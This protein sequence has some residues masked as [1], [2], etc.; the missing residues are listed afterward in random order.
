MTPRF[1]TGPGQSAGAVRRHLD[2]RQKGVGHI[3]FH[4][5]NV[6]T[7]LR[8]LEQTLHGHA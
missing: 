6:Y 5:M 4:L 3:S 2:V 7:G 8:G 1:A